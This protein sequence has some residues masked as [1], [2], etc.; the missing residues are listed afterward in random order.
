MIRALTFYFYFILIHPL[1]RYYLENDLS[2]R[3]V[4]FV[5]QSYGF[6]NRAKGTTLQF[7]NPTSFVS[8]ILEC[9]EGLQADHLINQNH[10]NKMRSQEYSYSLH[11][12]F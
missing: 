7:L 12:L 5:T 4:A 3:L 8:A 10:G 9:R 2:N 1:Y 6:G 11:D